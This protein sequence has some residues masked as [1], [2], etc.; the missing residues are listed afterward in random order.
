MKEDSE[1]IVM[2]IVGIKMVMRTNVTKPIRDSI[3][4]KRDGMKSEERLGSNHFRK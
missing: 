1:V 2:E 4:H 3:K